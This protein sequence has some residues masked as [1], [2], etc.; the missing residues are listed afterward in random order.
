MNRIVLLLLLVL[1]VRA[2]SAQPSDASVDVRVFYDVYE[3]ESPV[4]KRTLRAADLSAYPAFGLAVPVMAMVAWQRGASYEPAYRMMVAE[5][6]A[7]VAA[8]ALKRLYGR[9][10]PYIEREDVTSRANALDAWLLRHDPLSFPSGHAALSFAMAT[11]LALSYPQW[12]VVL[13]ATSWAVLVSVSRIWLGVHYPSDVL[14]GALTG[15]AV[16]TGT[17]LLRDA[18]TP[19]FVAS[20]RRGPPGIVLVSFSVPL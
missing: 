11:S 5:G 8:S 9:D 13:P 10:R 20:E 17:H 18:I 1:P 6:A 7:V 15:V 19:A 4:A 16:G 14:I 2:A 3:V 12:E